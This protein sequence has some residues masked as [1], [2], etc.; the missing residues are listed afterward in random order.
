MRRSLRGDG[1]RPGHRTGGG[2]AAPRQG[3]TVVAIERDPAALRGSTTIPRPR[4]SASP[5]TPPTRPSP[6]WRPTS[7]G[8]RRLWPAGSTTPRCSATRG[9][10]APPPGEMLDADRAQPRPAL[11]GCATAVRRFMAA[12]TRGAIDNVSSHQAQPAVP[13]ASRT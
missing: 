12:G 2:R 13:G 11:A 1:R 4:L 5:V 7:R 10:H 3:D 6:G 8:P 9:P